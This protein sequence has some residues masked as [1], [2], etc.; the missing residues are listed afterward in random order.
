MNAHICLIYQYVAH[1]YRSYNNALKGE[2]RQK[3]GNLKMIFGI[4][5]VEVKI[6]GFNIESNFVS[7]VL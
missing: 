2:K 1:K 4:G 6:L 5:L 3:R 7:H